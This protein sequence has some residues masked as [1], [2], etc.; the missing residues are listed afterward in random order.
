VLGSGRSVIVDAS[1]RTRA[2]RER[3]RRLAR[4]LDAAFVFVECRVPVEVCRQRLHERAAG[5]SISDGRAEILDAF[6]ERYE[7][8]SELSADE[9]VVV[10]SAGPLAESLGQLARH[11]LLSKMTNAAPAAPQPL[12]APLNTNNGESS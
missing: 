8:V 2:M 10:H 5:P 12:T 4:E 9:H 3:A 7:P 11:E 6:L 1:F